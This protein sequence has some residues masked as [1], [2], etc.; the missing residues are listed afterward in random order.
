MQPCRLVQDSHHI[1]LHIFPNSTF[2]FL[3]LNRKWETLNF[4][5]YWLVLAASQNSDYRYNCCT[6][7]RQSCGP[8]ILLAKPSNGAPG[9]CV[10]S[11]CSQACLFE[12]AADGGFC[13]GVPA[14]GAFWTTDRQ[15]SSPTPH[16][17][18]HIPMMQAT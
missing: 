17:Y 1:R 2:Y 13:L 10:R 9:A 11:V 5:S 8:H 18:L 12:R 15:V 7:R 3:R 16:G 6:G 4:P 14:V